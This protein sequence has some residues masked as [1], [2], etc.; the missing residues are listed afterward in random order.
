MNEGEDASNLAI[1]HKHGPLA[2]DISFIHIGGLRG[3]SRAPPLPPPYDEQRCWRR[4]C[5]QKKQN[6]GSE[7]AFISRKHPIL[8][9]RS[10]VPFGQHR[11]SRPLTYESDA[12]RSQGLSCTENPFVHETN[13]PNKVSITFLFLS[14][15]GKIQRC[16]IGFLTKDHQ[17]TEIRGIY[18]FVYR[19]ISNSVLV[20]VSKCVIPQLIVHPILLNRTVLT[21]RS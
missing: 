6:L 12:K 19:K 2:Q 4:P 20:S 21:F 8:V 16:R 13:V 3:T 9:P 1:E 10:R 5:G 7:N 15:G 14:N 18:I 17:T 11:E